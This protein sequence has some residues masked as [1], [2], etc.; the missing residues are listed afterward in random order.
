MH[1]FRRRRAALGDLVDSRSAS[2]AI[3]DK[4]RKRE[5]ERQLRWQADPTTPGG[6]NNPLRFSDVSTTAAYTLPASITGKFVQ[7]DN[8]PP[9]GSLFV[10]QRSSN[11][12]VGGGLMG[13]ACVMR[14]LQINFDLVSP[15][16]VN[17]STMFDPAG[18][19]VALVMD[20]SANGT[21]AT[22]EMVFKSDPLPVY[23]STEMLDNP[24]RNVTYEDRFRVLKTWR[25][26]IKPIAAVNNAAANTISA[27][28]SRHTVSYY[29]PMAVKW[30]SLPPGDSGTHQ[31]CADINFFLIAFIT[32]SSAG[33]VMHV[34]ARGRFTSY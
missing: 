19:F 5:R 1:P 20:R 25:F 18:A 8:S 23:S 34:N 15:T 24:L 32:D 9:T 12:A 31:D 2:Y 22:A 17:Q 6:P 3:N 16:I 29:L 4:E 21:Q 26:D 13:S 28:I 10:P 30:S 7:L 14:S 27:S 11:D 33:T